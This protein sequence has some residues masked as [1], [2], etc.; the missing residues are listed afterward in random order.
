MMMAIKRLLAVWISLLCISLPTLPARAETFGEQMVHNTGF[1]ILDEDGNPEGWSSYKGWVNGYSKLTTERVHSGKYAVK[2]STDTNEAP[3][4]MYKV[5][6]SPNTKYQISA[7]MFTEDVVGY[8]AVKVEWS[9][10]EDA[11]LRGTDSAKLEGGSGVWNDYLGTAESMGDV[12]YI[13]IY[14]R[15]YG[16]GTLYVDD[17]ELYAIS[18]PP[19]GGITTDESIFYP[20][21]TEGNAV[22]KANS[23]AYNNVQNGK[24]DLFLKDGESILESKTGVQLEKAGTDWTFSTKKMTEEAKPYTLEAVFYNEAG[25]NIGSSQKT[26]YRFNRPAALNENG[27]YYVDG[28]LFIPHIAYHVTDYGIAV[29][30]N[31]DVENAETQYRLIRDAG[32]NVVQMSTGCIY[33]PNV[34]LQTLDKLH[35]FGLKGL[36]TLY[37]K[38]IPPARPERAETIK[39]LIETIKDHPAVFAYGI[40]DEPAIGNHGLTEQEL[41][42]SYVLIR[43]ID[44]VHPTYTVIAPGKND[45]DADEK[46]AS[47]IRQ[48]LTKYTDVLCYDPYVACW[49]DVMSTYVYE[50]HKAA[51]EF[52]YH[53]R[54]CYTLNQICFW[55]DYFPTADEY[56]HM[57]YQAAIGGSKGVGAYSFND[58]FNQHG[59]TPRKGIWED[60]LWN[61]ILKFKQDSEMDMA[62]EYFHTGKYPI[63]NEERTKDYLYRSYVDGN[64]L[65]MV[66][67]RLDETR[68]TSREEQPPVPVSIPLVSANGNVKIG[69]YTAKLLYGAPSKTQTGSGTLEMSLG[70]RKA[71]VYKI[72][73]SQTTDYSSIS[74]PGEE[75]KPVV[76]ISGLHDME[77]YDWAAEAVKEMVDGGAMTATGMFRPAEKITRA[78]FAGALLRTLSLSGEQGENFEDVS[79]ET[80]YAKEIAIGKALGILQGTGENLYQPDAAITR[81]DLVT[82]V[83]RAVEATGK[84]GE[85]G[86]LTFPDAASVSEYARDAVSVMAGKGIV[87]G[88]EEGFFMPQNFTSRAEAAIILHR[89][90]NAAWKEIEKE[91]EPEPEKPKEEEKVQ[92]AFSEGEVSETE[93]ARRAESVKLLEA[94]GILSKNDIVSEEAVTRGKAA[95]ILV[96]LMGDKTEKNTTTTEF[97]DAGDMDAH[98]GY[99]KAAVDMGLMSGYGDGTFGTDDPLTYG[100]AV[101][102]LVDALGYKAHAESMG[103]Y[104]AG[105][106]TRAGQIELTK[107]I[108]ILDGPIR[109]GAFARLVENALHIPVASPDGFGA[110]AD[111]SFVI[112]D[113]KTLLT[114]NHNINRYE[115]VLS[116]TFMEELVT[117]GHALKKGQVVIDGVT[118]D[119]KAVGADALFARR[120]IAYAK[121]SDDTPEL[122]YIRIKENSTEEIIDAKD[123]LSGNDGLL[124]YGT[125]K[126][127]EK[128]SLAG[129]KLVYNGKPE[130]WDKDWIPQTGKVTLV[131]WGGNIEAVVVDAYEIYIVDHV[132]RENNILYF[133]DTA[134]FPEGIEFNETDTSQK[135]MLTDTEGNS[136]KATLCDEW[137]IVS[138]AKSRTG[139]VMRAVRSITSVTGKVTES[140]QDTVTVD[141]T[142]YGV[143]ENIKQN[144]KLTKPTLG[145][146]AVF[147]LDMMGEIAAVNTSVKEYMYGFLVNGEISKGID[148]MQRLKIFSENGKMTVLRTADNISLNGITKPGNS[149]LTD[150]SEVYKNGKIVRQLVRYV[151]NADGD[152]ITELYTATDYSGRDEKGEFRFIDPTRLE[153]FSMDDWIN[154]DKLYEAEKTAVGSFYGGTLRMFGNRYLIRTNTKIFMIPGENA[155]DDQYSL[156]DPSSLQHEG[157]PELTNFGIYDTDEDSAVSAICW[158]TDNSALGGETPD[159]QKDTAALVKSISKQL[160]ED[161]EVIE[162]INLINENGQEFSM[163]TKPDQNIFFQ[164]VLTDMQKD[165]KTPNGYREYTTIPLKET[166]N[167]AEVVN[168]SP[169]DVIAYRIDNSRNA[170]CINYLFRSKYPYMQEQ[171]IDTFNSVSSYDAYN[172]YWSMCIS[173]CEVLHVGKYG[174]SAKTR[175]NNS[176]SFTYPTYVYGT[177]LLY[178]SKKNA[179]QK[180]SSSDI[181]EGDKVFYKRKQIYTNFMVVYR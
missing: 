107:G 8:V 103:G 169:G 29:L 166:V 101:K 15:L 162:V 105:Y 9:S 55:R 18:Q 25:E 28:K 33:D 128:V 79:E 111:G 151:V 119:G 39:T 44:K 161:G 152:C 96:R 89:V 53:D 137:N 127:E 71:L 154:T 49:D 181:R 67:L 174:I 140:A 75:T 129:A 1:E 93:A 102:I 160:G 63:F 86:T 121:K 99:I 27:N 132:D 56:R 144:E 73:P 118:L 61:D 40:Y 62:D 92:I 117:P 179:V 88:N 17:V 2:I 34:A 41:L 163:I 158:F 178:D 113:G 134:D 66:I 159:Y 143:A 38:T 42:D 147:Y 47:M 77:G 50:V 14:M 106:L 167:G 59:E 48:Q 172:N 126:G 45:S 157:G 148:N 21:W 133:K 108:E 19:A 10:P 173:F 3:W 46:R 12:G 57:W 98:S 24:V 6:A 5:P 43:S 155:A 35:E 123:I 74:V 104:L 7:K 94:L 125:E 97:S 138:V 175:I 81:Q 149:L 78:E 164:N 20:E 26:L 58:A 171:R 85:K 54:P 90:K 83:L 60:P 124:I 31:Q 30:T 4:V 180:I 156:M 142:T 120:V 11:W 112:E 16:T 87:V 51:E 13:W 36:V 150:T 130:A 165:P 91:E 168:L 170:L 64:D 72:T 146:T 115:G 116:A 135:V 69:E 84:T 82:I 80:P 109:G 100:A 110:D 65:Y 23:A 136:L 141:G 145:L 37:D 52:A 131:M 177:I 122:L 70:W 139:E 68:A 32:Y 95:K 76:D 22:I 114:E 176:Q 153:T